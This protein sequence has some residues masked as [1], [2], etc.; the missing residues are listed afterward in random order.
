HR[1]IDDAHELA[2]GILEKYRPRL[3]YLANKLIDVETLEGP[4]LENVFT[5]PIPGDVSEEAP[6]TKEKADTGIKTPA[7]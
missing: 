3:V 6:Q 5:D 1:L 7:V 4:E 2:K